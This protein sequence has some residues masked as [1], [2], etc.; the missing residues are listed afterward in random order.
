MRVEY[1]I[2]HEGGQLT[3]EKFAVPGADILFG[4]FGGHYESFLQSDGATE[5]WSAGLWNSLRR[6]K[7]VL[8]FFPRRRANATGLCFA[9]LQD[10]ALIPH[11]CSSLCC[12]PA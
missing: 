6:E 1:T 5:L 3:L 7:A 10:T 9:T 4:L 8:F 11:S 2:R 12:F